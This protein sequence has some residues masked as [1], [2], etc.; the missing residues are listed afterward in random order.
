MKF[1][2]EA[3]GWPTLI[4]KKVVIL[5]LRMRPP[6]ASLENFILAAQELKSLF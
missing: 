4:I 3:R 2:S 1:S 5:M 6:L